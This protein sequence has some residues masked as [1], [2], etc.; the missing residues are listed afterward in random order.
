MFRKRPHGGF[1]AFCASEHTEYVQENNIYQRKVSFESQK[2]P[3][4]SNFDLKS[5]I[6]AGLPLEKTSTI[7]R[8]GS[9]DASLL[10]PKADD[11]SNSKTKT[12]VKPKTEE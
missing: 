12:D 3:P 2:L 7:I 6:D 1:S 9:F 8:Q 10:E 5:I 4:V 11:K